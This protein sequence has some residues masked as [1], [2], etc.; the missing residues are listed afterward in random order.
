MIGDTS[1]CKIYVFKFV[2][3]LALLNFLGP[4]KSGKKCETIFFFFICKIHFLK[5]KKK[6]IFGPTFGG[7]PLVGCPKQWR[8]WDKLRASFGIDW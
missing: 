3:S 6:I 7:L 4:L 1:I 2:L 5:K 8:K